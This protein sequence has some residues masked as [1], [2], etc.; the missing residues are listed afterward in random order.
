M[1][2]TK[3]QGAAIQ[4]QGIKFA[5]AIVQPHILTT[6]DKTEANRL[7]AVFQNQIFGVPVVLMAP[8]PMAHV[9]RYYG[10]EDLVKFLANTP[11]DRI[12]WKDFTITE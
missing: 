8:D 7:I 11:V 10:R 1:S 3:F 9:P 5:V 6:P 12:P 2:V 4:E